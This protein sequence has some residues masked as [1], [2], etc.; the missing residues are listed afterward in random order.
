M[1]N[2]QYR[3]PAELD[4]EID[5]LSLYGVIWRGR[6]II[7]SITAVV[8][9]LI[10]GY[11]V[12]TIKLP[13]DKSP[14]PNLYKPQ[15][16][17]LINNSSSSGLASAISS[18]GLGSL[19]SLAGVSAGGGY[20]ELA[21][22]LLE[23]PDILDPIA[24]R[25]HIAERYHIKSF[26]VGNSRN[27]LL[28]H[29]SAVFDPKTNTVTVSYQDYDP[30]FATDVVN[31]MVELLA[32]QFTTI[33]G[34]RNL[35]REDL[36][37]QKVADVKAQITRLSDEVA[38]FQ[39][40]HGLLSVTALATEQ[41]T[42]LAQLRAALISKEVQIQTY[43]QF[44]RIDDPA[45]AQLR[46]ERDNLKKLVG[47]MENG[48]ST[49][50]DIGPTQKDIPGLAM[51]FEK[52]KLNLTVQSKIYE[53]LTQQYELAKLAAQGEEPIFQEL[54]PATVPDLKS[55]PSRG[56]MVV[57]TI[58]AAFILST[59]FVIARNSIRNIKLSPE[60]M[61]RFRGEIS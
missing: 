41:A 56:I 13:P 42:A 58:F 47:E 51:Q 16:L 61:K 55:G 12:I 38:A 8:A 46:A 20:G 32:K 25:F 6:K 34:N 39:R 4:E 33:G 15:A 30:K 37:G 40:Q 35:T 2:E 49:Y 60:Q 50:S 11:A 53:I 43:T 24:K 44:S 45:L 22:K 54:Q 31:A 3:R 7:I 10:I 52:L 9:V 57:V 59:I 5:L 29:S 36:L 14:L 17:I 28:K 18:S 1:S 21:V 26:I 27:A 48:Y 19:A 23:S